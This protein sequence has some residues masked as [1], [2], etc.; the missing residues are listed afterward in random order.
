MDVLNI[1]TVNEG[2]GRMDAERGDSWKMGSDVWGSISDQW[3]VAHIT[4]GRGCGGGGGGG[5]WGGG[6][7]GGL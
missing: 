4:G 2:H 6:G 1:R 5:G 3:A 7:G